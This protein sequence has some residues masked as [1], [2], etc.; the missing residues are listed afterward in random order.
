MAIKY[1]WKIHA[2]NYL[3]GQLDGAVSS[4]EWKY[5]ATETVKKT[6]YT[7]DEAGTVEL[8]AP[9][10]DNF[11]SYSE[12]TEQQIISWVE[13][14]IGEEEISQKQFRLSTII[15]N[16]KSSSSEQAFE[17]LPWEE[18]TPPPS[19]PSA[20]PMPESPAIE[21]PH[22]LFQEVNQILRVDFSF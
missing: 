2:L 19:R 10:K 9:E 15:E 13:G 14:I 18:P 7:A 8:P 20:E 16:Q 12:L 5:I 4:V 17:T 22:T 11:V 3:R 1:S 21:I 6:T